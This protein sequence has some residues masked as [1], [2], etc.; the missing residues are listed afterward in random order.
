[1]ARS[2]NMVILVGHLGKDPELSYLPSGQ[3]VAKFTLATNRSFKKGEEWQE[4]T[5]WH[6]IVAWGKL[7]EFCT[8]YLGKGRQAFVEG[9]LRTRN[10]EDREGKQ[11]TSVE[12][13]ANEVVPLGPRGEGMGEVPGKQAAPR[14]AKADEGIGESQQITDDDIPF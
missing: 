6:N 10:W 7:G 9:R 8:Q 1:M 14:T 11:R 4:E 2:V 3:S 12:I 5:E 13:V